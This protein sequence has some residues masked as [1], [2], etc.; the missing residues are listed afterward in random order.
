MP[1]VLRL[2]YGPHKLVM[3][4]FG[5]STSP[6]TRWLSWIEA[7]SVRRSVS[8]VYDYDYV[9]EA[10]TVWFDLRLTSGSFPGLSRRHSS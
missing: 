10:S 1:A 4:S 6:Y 2:D 8:H 3:E 9:V 5:G 7:E